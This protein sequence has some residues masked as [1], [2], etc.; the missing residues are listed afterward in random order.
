MYTCPLCR[1]KTLGIWHVLLAQPGQV[2]SCGNC[3]GHVRVQHPGKAVTL[4]PCVLGLLAIG[5]S[6]N[7][8]VLDAAILVM[9]SSWL[10][11]L[12]Y[13]CVSLTS[14]PPSLDGA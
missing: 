6:G 10:F 12:F 3:Q 13:R 11:L 14:I 4:M 7:N 9:M 2:L 5:R 8:M 1:T